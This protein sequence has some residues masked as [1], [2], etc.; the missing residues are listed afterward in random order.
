[1]LSATYMAGYLFDF[2]FESDTGPDVGGC[3]GDGHL[4]RLL[5]LTE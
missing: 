2:S 5:V 4:A 1:M 3:D